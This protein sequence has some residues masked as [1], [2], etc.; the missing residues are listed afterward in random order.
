ML[1]VALIANRS[2]EAASSLRIGPSFRANYNLPNSD[3]CQSFHVSPI[4]AL[5]RYRQ[6]RRSSRLCRLAANK[7]QRSKRGRRELT[8]ARALVC[9][10][11][12]LVA[13]MGLRTNFAFGALIGCD[14][15]GTYLPAFLLVGILAWWQ[16]RR[17]GWCA[18][19]HRRRHRRCTGEQVVLVKLSQQI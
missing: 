12:R 15:L 8:A 11:V 5:R 4:V 1:G 3:M 18:C 14:A 2:A 19:P 17:S 13:T 7:V 16:R 6:T 10:K 9:S